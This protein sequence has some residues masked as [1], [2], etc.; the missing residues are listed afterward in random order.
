MTFP[1]VGVVMFDTPRERLAIAL[2]V[3]DLSCEEALLARLDR[4]SAWTKVG[5][6]LFVASGP[7]TVEMAAKHGPVFLDLKLHDIPQTVARA[8]A[9]TTRIGA[10]LLTVHAGGG[11]AMMEAACDGAG[12]A[13]SAVGRPRPLLVGVTLLTSLGSTDLPSL[14]I[15][16]SV[17]DHV[18]R[19]VDLSLRGGLDGIVCSPH[20]AAGIRA[21]TGPGFRIVTPGVRPA[22]ASADDQ[23]RVATPGEAIA[24]GADLL[25]VGRPVTRAPDPAAATRAVIDEIAVAMARRT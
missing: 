13:A 12:E 25:V 18:R 15:E 11:L 9:S 17:S 1:G 5:L 7:A 24:S 14:G 23:A 3:P 20:E 16:G 2:D 6:E 8:A 22:G 19:L 4:A 10:A 21:R